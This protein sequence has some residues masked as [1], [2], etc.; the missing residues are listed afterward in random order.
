MRD[1]RTLI[2]EQAQRIIQGGDVNSDV[3]VT[4]EELEIYV[5]QAFG[6]FVYNSFYENKKEDNESSVNGTFIYSFV[7]QV[8][9][10]KERDKYYVALS[11]TYVN[12]PNGMGVYSVSPL[13]DEF[14]TYIPLRTDFLSITRGT[15]VGSL[16]GNKGYYIE[17]TRL[18]LHNLD[19]S[20]IPEKLLVKLAGGIQNAK[21]EDNV[22]LPLNVQEDLVRMTVQLY[23]TMRQVPQDVINDNIK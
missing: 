13:Q 4:K 19:K 18:Y 9:C 5:D 10:D 11:S 20:A 14:N 16:E 2:A 8:K 22:D 6:K 12:L 15:L 7:E 17:N 1:T 23:M 3:Q 21:H